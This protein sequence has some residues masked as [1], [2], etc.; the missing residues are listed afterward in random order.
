MTAGVCSITAGSAAIIRDRPAFAGYRNL[1]LIQRFSNGRISDLRIMTCTYFR[2]PICARSGRRRTL[3]RTSGGARPSVARVSGGRRQI[4]QLPTKTRKA[5]APIST[6]L[7]TTP[8]RL[9]TGAGRFLI[10]SFQRA[11]PE[12]RPKCDR[13][14]FKQKI[15]S[16]PWRIW[17]SATF[18]PGADLAFFQGGGGFDPTTMRSIV[19]ILMSKPRSGEPIFFAILNPRK[20]CFPGIY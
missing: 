20:W 5:P 19:A 15:R 8:V 4:Y 16:T 14:H 12:P 3:G 17:N 13:V 9:L 2:C 1:F 6:G 7:R 18:G 10:T 11:L